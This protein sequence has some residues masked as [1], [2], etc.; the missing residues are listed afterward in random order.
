M[1]GPMEGTGARPPVGVEFQT[2]AAGSARGFVGRA[3]PCLPNPE[4]AGQNGSLER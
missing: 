4:P 1:E 2:R 3:N